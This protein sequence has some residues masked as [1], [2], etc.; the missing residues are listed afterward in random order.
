MKRSI[1][2]AVAAIIACSSLAPAMAQMTSMPSGSS[3]QTMG[4]TS[5]TEMHT[6]TTTHTTTTKPAAV[7]R[8]TPRRHHKVA[9]RT[10]HH[11]MVKATSTSTEVK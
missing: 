10:V 4:N 6:T 1:S 7:V 2:T 3:S 9:H 5:H 11:T 8:H